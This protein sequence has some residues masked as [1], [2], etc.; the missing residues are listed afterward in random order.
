MVAPVRK[1]TR[2]FLALFVLMTGVGCD[3]ITKQIAAEKLSAS[4]PVSFL[5]DTVRMQY[6]ENSGAFLGLGHT[7]PRALR[8][9]LLTV[10]TAGLLGLLAWI[11]IVKWDMRRTR[12]TAVALILAGGMGN[13]IDRLLQDGVVVDFINLGVGPVRTGIFNVADVAITSGVIILLTESLR[14]HI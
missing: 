7:L 11:L 9:W 8:F 6:A 1:T 14:K 5:G 12:F 3:Q 13:L 4:A 2:L 10:S